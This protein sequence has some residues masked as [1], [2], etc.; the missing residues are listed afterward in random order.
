MITACINSYA[1]KGTKY[2]HMDKLIGVGMNPAIGKNETGAFLSAV[3]FKGRFQHVYEIGFTKGDIGSLGLSESSIFHAGYA[4]EFNLAN[5]NNT[6]FAGLGTGGFFAY[7][8]ISNQILE[9]TFNSYTPGISFSAF[10]EFYL[11]DN[12]SLNAAFKQNYRFNS[13]IGDFFWYVPVGIRYVF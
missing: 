4:R 2:R 12:I 13:K 5:V 8:K 11:S 7:E 10:T 6:L 1:V 3:M 9:E